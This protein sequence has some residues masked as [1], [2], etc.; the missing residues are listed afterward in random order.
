[1]EL[2]QIQVFQLSIEDL[3]LIIRDAVANELKKISNIF[4]QPSQENELLSREETS[5]L[6]KVS[7]TTLFN[8]NREKILEAKKIGRKVFYLKSEVF[9]KLNDVA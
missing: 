1:M 7:Y 3:S 5:K 6:L 4:K 9:N 8:W 2:K